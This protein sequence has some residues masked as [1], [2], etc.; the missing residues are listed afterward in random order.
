MTTPRA[1]VLAFLAA[2]HGDHITEQHP[3]VAHLARLRPP[4][5]HDQR[6]LAAARALDP[7]TGSA[8]LDS[9]RR[10]H[11]HAIGALEHARTLLLAAAWAEVTARGL[12]VRRASRRADLDRRQITAALQHPTRP[13]VY[14][15]PQAVTRGPAWS[16]V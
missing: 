12:S 8:A 16:P 3:V 5:E 13:L 4:D 1:D 9:R 6:W 2:H 10:E 7:L 11:R 15:G 14:D